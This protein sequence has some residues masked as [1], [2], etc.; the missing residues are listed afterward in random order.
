MAVLQASERLALLSQCVLLLQG[1]LAGW[2]SLGSPELLV[3]ANT[4]QPCG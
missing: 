1:T 3:A 2:W 4:R